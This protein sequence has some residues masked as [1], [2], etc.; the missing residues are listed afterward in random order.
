DS[1]Y[2]AAVAGGTPQAVTLEERKRMPARTGEYTRDRRRKVFVRDGDVMILDVRT[3]RQT[4]LTN[5]VD[6]ESHPRFLTDERLVTFQRNGNVFLRDLERGTETQ[7]TNLTRDRSPDSTLGEAR[8]YLRDEALHVSDVLAERKR[9]REDG[10]SLASLLRDPKPKPF[11]L[12]RR[13]PSALN[14][15][16]D[17][18]VVT[19]VL[20]PSPEDVLRTLVPSYVTEQG[21]TE[22]LTARPKVGSPPPAQEFFVHVLS[23]D[24]VMRVKPDAIVGQDT[25][26]GKARVRPVAWF[27]PWWSDDG[28]QAFV[29]MFSRDNKDRWIVMLDVNRGELGPV[30]DHQHDEAWIGGP[31]I[32]SGS[33]GGVVG[34]MPD[35]KRVYFQS[36][37]DGFS[38]LYV[39]GS[40]GTG[41]RPLTSGRF[42]VYGLRMSLDK[43]RWYFTSNELHFGERHLYSMPL[44]GGPRT[45][46]TTVEGRVDAFFSPDEKSIAFLHSFSNRPPELY[47]MNATP[48]AR[49]RKVTDS[50]SREFRSYDWRVPE[51]LTFRARDGAEVPARLYVPEKPNGAAVIFVHGAG[52]LQNAHKWWSSYFR[53]Y[54]FHNLLADNGYVVMDIDYRASAGHGRDWRTA[55]YRHM[56]G[57]D[58]D[59]NV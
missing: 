1:L 51:V 58:L 17:G 29:Q 21:F 22:T 56:G 8:T 54:M 40:D 43:R 28:R 45:R 41:K 46:I 42:E 16:P 44:E 10:E 4:R 20:S 6:E 39:A 26:G 7:V 32:R 53:E 12:G 33:G 2:K 27:G 23:T 30:I 9:K 47:V 14:L 19:F 18:R 49:G 38:H 25:V 15:S 36:E 13:N 11:H 59:D 48:G 50:P 37:A 34:W 52:Y 31:G 35:G 24:S 57:K 55:I 5:T 3:G